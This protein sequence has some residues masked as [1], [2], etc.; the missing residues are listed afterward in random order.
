MGE[1]RATTQAGIGLVDNLPEGFDRLVCDFSDRHNLLVSLSRSL[2]VIGDERI[3]FRA[4][5]VTIQCEIEPSSVDVCVFNHFGI[6][7]RRGRS[8]APACDGFKR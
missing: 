1:A 5:G 7:F 4:F 8:L 6:S 3:F 2:C